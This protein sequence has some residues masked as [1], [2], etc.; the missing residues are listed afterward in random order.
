MN[1]QVT[2]RALGIRRQI[3]GVFRGPAALGGVLDQPLPLQD[4]F[5]VDVVLGALRIGQLGAGEVLR[6][7]VLIVAVMTT[8]RRR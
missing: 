7:V 6:L 1:S 2:G 3:A 4:F 8:S 5:P